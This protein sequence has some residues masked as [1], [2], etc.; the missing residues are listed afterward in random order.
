MGQKNIHQNTPPIV[1][2]LKELNHKV[3]LD[4]E[5]VVFN[6]EGIPDFDV[7]GKEEIPSTRNILE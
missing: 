2:A 3:V 6:K 5:V 1:S 7:Y 4:G